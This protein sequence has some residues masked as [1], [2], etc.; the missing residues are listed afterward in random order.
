[1]FY[2]KW[3]DKGDL[4]MYNPKEGF[5]CYDDSG[6]MSTI[7]YKAES[8]ISVFMGY[9]HSNNWDICEIYVISQEKNLLVSQH[10]ITLISK[11]TEL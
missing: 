10:D 5:A 11:N 9:P 2:E 4:V 3:F 1:M 8:Q 6:T 7:D